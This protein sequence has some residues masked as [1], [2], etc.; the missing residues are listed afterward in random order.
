MFHRAYFI[1]YVTVGFK[2]KHCKTLPAL[3]NYRCARRDVK[4]EHSPRNHNT[5]QGNLSLL[6]FAL[7]ERHLK[8]ELMIFAY[9]PFLFFTAS[10]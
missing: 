6:S 3:F 10:R 4:I 2:R 7:R 9:H 5:H 8:I 1:T